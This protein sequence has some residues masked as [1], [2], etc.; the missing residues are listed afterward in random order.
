MFFDLNSLYSYDQ[1]AVK[2]I[3]GVSWWINALGI[4]YCH[5]CAEGSVLA[6]EVSNAAGMTGRRKRKEGRKEKG[7][8]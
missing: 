2:T 3:L 4:Q 1:I 7:L 6:W 5:C 8:T